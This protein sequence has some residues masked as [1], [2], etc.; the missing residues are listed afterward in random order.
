MSDN[1]SIFVSTIDLER[2]YALLENMKSLPEALVRLEDELDRANIVEPECIPDNVVTMNSTVI[3]KFI[4]NEKQIQK[5]LV[6]PHEVKT[7]D[8]ISIFAP[9]GSALLGLS[10]GQQLSW[11]MPD[12]NERT[13]EILD[14]VYQPER[15]GEYC[16]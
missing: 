13:I 14:V 11:P 3:F 8:E 4:G 16:V 2:I 12:G 15:S 1:S 10:V 5:K 7:N 9:I 6:Y